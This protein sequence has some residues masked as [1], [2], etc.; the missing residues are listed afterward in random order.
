MTANLNI[1]LRCWNASK[2]AFHLWK[3][4]ELIDCLTGIRLNC[5]H[6]SL[7]SFKTYHL[8]S[9]PWRKREKSGKK[10]VSV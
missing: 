8:K 4:Q 3:S 6:A 9:T 5:L 2:N 10:D 7:H 1:T